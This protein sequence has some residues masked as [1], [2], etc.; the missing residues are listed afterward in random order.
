MD[1]ADDGPAISA[2]ESLEAGG[3]HTAGA[4]AESRGLL[5]HVVTSS[6]PDQSDAPR[7]TTASVPHESGG[8]G[9][10]P[11]FWSSQQHSV[12]HWDTVRNH[13]N[14]RVTARS[15]ELDKRSQLHL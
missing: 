3:R 8:G 6:R 1:Q 13:L 4:N 5:S 11:A 14:K 10:I 9:A 2:S 12:S 7:R 15:V